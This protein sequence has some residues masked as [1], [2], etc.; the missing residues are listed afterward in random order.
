M[1]G[2]LRLA[3]EILAEMQPGPELVTAA[4]PDTTAVRWDTGRLNPGAEQN[5]PG[6]RADKMH[7]ICGMVRDRAR[8][9]GVLHQLPQ[10]L[11]TADDGAV[12]EL[13]GTYSCGR[14]GI[15]TGP[16]EAGTRWPD[17]TSA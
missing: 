15:L 3:G 2:A 9:I 16:P 17:G 14:T 6:Y 5:L 10:I 4:D 11:L 12:I 1:T 7:I 13:F 8:G